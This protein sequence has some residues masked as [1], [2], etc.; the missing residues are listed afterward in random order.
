LLYVD[1]I[2]ALFFFFKRKDI[3]KWELRLGPIRLKNLN[4]MFFF[5]L[6]TVEF[7]AMDQFLALG[8]VGSGAFACLE[9]VGHPVRRVGNPR[10]NVSGSS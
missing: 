7:A 9:A 4:T 5:F 8:L 3:T 10:R 1:L 2:L 6:H